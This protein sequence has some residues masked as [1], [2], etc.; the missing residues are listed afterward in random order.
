MDYLKRHL[1]IPM[2]MAALV[3]AAIVFMRIYTAKEAGTFELRDLS[4]DRSALEDVTISGDLRDGY[5]RTHFSIQGSL[6]ET[7]T[8]IYDNVAGRFSN[9]Y[10]PGAP[11]IIDGIQHEARPSFVGT[12]D[13]DITYEDRRNLKNITSGTGYVKTGLTYHDPRKS[14]NI[15]MITDNMDTSIITGTNTNSGSGTSTED[16]S[17]QYFFMNHLNYGITRIGDKVYFTVPT[18]SDYTGTNGIYEITDF[19]VGGFSRP[20]EKAAKELVTIDL[21]NNRKEGAPKIE[22]LG[23]EAVGDKLAL[24][25]AEDNKLTLR[26]FDSRSGAELGKVTMD[27]IAIQD[28]ASFPADSKEETHY[29]AYEAHIDHDVQV[30]NLILSRGPSEPDDV[31]TTMLSFDLSNGIKWIDTVKES[32]PREEIDRFYDTTLI[33][34]RQGKL[35][36]VKTLIES[37]EESQVP[38][39]IVRPKH[40]MIY[41]YENAK[42]VYKGELVT[43]MNDDIIRVMNLPPSTGGFGYDEFDYRHFD[44]LKIE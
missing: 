24:I 21:D 26:R 11:K 3:I 36:V 18:T 25:L 12:F 8:E 23:L 33:S 43:D 42:L 39:D 44:N 37:E 9:R 7:A 40:L 35:Y 19:T 22:V 14:E 32:Y 29:A 10:S 1:A 5:H 41:V 2:L 13:F 15:G 4:G 6:V 31:K 38:Y 17:R 30:I 34:H 27:D 16:S 20:S 28:N